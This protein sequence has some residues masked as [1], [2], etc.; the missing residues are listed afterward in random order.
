MSLLGGL[1]SIGNTSLLLLVVF[2]VLFLGFAFGRIKIKGISLGE[3]G[4]FLIALLVGALF[5]G[6]SDNG[7]LLLRFSS[8]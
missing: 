8:N 3:A 7:D 1:I 4:V 2:A 5:F 6:V